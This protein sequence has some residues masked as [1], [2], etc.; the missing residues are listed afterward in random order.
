M[1]NDTSTGYVTN[2]NSANVNGAK[3]LTFSPVQ[4]PYLSRVTG[5]KFAQT[6]DFAMSAQYALEAD[7]Q[8]SI[9]EADSLTAPTAVAYDMSNETN[10][11]Q[12]LQASVNV[13]YTAMSSSNRLKITES[14]TSGFGYTGDPLQSAKMEMLA[15]QIA[16]AQEQLYGVLEFSALNGTKTDS[17][18]ANVANLMGG[19]LKSVATS[20]V[21]A[22]SAALDKG[23]IDELLLEMATA[24][25]RFAR[26]V[27]FANAFQKMALTKIYGYVPAAQGVGGISIDQLITDFGQWEIVYS[28]RIPT[29]DILFAD[30]SDVSLINQAVPGKSYMPDGLFFYE[31]L[32]KTGASEKGQMYGQLSIDFGSEKLHGSI[33]SLANS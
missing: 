24:G 10:L 4:Y 17:T 20:T 23:M 14:G 22:S 21:D 13:S 5:R 9:T 7:S 2:W 8:V 16:R 33:T 26:P 3:I 11:I 28:R 25:A 32:S 30:M 18:A 12:I 29:D 27:I 19:V 6:P 1:A 15:F 31:A